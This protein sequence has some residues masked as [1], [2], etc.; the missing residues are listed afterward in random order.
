MTGSL[1]ESSTAR[2]AGLT[3]RL[4]RSKPTVTGSEFT[5]DVIGRP[6][7]PMVRVLATDGAR[8]GEAETNFSYKR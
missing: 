2:P 7:K 6:A 4:S 8:S 5:L 1:R 3:I